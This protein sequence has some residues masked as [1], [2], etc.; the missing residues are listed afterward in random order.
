MLD[1]TDFFAI[2]VSSRIKATRKMLVKLTREGIPQNP[3][4]IDVKP[5]IS[6]CQD[7]DALELTSLCANFSSF[8]RNVK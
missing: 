5:V 3:P 2:L 7:L 4:V 8:S 6:R 1:L